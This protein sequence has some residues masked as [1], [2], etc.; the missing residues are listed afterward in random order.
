MT[1][2]PEHLF[3]AHHPDRKFLTEHCIHY[4]YDGV[5]S[6]A[7]TG[8]RPGQKTSPYRHSHD[9]YEF[10]IPYGP[11]PMLILKG[12]NY[13]GETGYVYPSNPGDIHG[14]KLKISNTP[15]DNVVID[16]TYFEDILAHLK[17]QNWHFGADLPLTE[18]T[19]SYIQLFK[20]EFNRKESCDSRKLQALSYLLSVSLIEA[21]SADGCQL[22]PSA[23]R[24]QKGMFQIAS[25]INTH[26][27]EPLTINMLADLCNISPTY[28]ISAFKK[29]IGVSPHQYLSRLRLSNARQL[30]ET[31]NYSVQ[32]IAL[33]CGF[34]KPNTFTSLFKSTH[35]MTP[36]QYRKAQAD[37][38]IQTD[39]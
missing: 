24:Y 35:G 8:V 19:K 22:E 2:S 3:A 7:S 6:I 11:I 14:T 36:Q 1:H 29:A 27:T 25:Y 21:G 15:H 31:S 38:H 18:D 26:Y 9:D 32:E 4:Y 10:L 23:Y 13:Y 33:M 12:E 5:I 39:Q 30:L 17:H 28:F 34:Q 20:R 16:K 37:D